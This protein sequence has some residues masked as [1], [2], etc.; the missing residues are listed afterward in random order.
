MIGSIFGCVCL[1]LY[2]ITLFHHPVYWID[3]IIN[4]FSAMWHG[5]LPMKWGNLKIKQY[6]AKAPEPRSRS[7]SKADMEQPINDQTHV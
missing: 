4:S 7:V 6:R 3:E 2:F 1:K 5:L